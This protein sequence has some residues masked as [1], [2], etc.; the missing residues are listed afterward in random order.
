MFPYSVRKR[1]RPGVESRLSLLTIAA[2]PPRTFTNVHPILL[3]PHSLYVG[4]GADQNMW[5]MMRLV[6]FSW[7]VSVADTAASVGRTLAG[8]V[9]E[10]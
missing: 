7:V 4:N 2:S 5:H 1:S 3:F 8:G 10:L 9:I 6:F